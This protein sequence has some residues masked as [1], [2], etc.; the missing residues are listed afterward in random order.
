MLQELHNN[1]I[2]PHA[3]RLFFKLNKNPNVRIS[4]DHTRTRRLNI[5][6]VRGGV[7]QDKSVPESVMQAGHAA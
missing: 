3:H 6:L 1:A 5:S 2:D 7:E 4:C